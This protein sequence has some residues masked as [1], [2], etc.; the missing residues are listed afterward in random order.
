MTVSSAS[1]VRKYI[2]CFST[3][4]FRLGFAPVSVNDDQHRDSLREIELIHQRLNSRSGLDGVRVPLMGMKFR[5][6]RKQIQL[7]LG[8]HDSSI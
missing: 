3:F 8:F 5:K 6:I 2:N 4:K 1:D 7:D